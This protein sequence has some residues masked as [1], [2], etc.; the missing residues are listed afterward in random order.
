MRYRFCILIPCLLFTFIYTGFGQEDAG[1]KNIKYE[2]DS[3]F[4]IDSK[5]T[6]GKLDNGL[7]YYI[8]VNKRPENRAELRLVVNVGSVLE[9]DN[10]QGLAHFAEHMAFNG[11]KN[12][13]KQELVDYL[14]SIGMRFG[15]ELNAYTSFD[16]TVYM[17][18]VPSDSIP[19]METAIKILE[20]WAHNVSYDFEE[21]EKE[22]GVIIEEWRLGRGAAARM[23]DQQFPIIFYNS[24]YAE[25]L[26]I[27]KKDILE[28]FEPQTLYDFYKKWYRPELM[29]VI[30]IGDFDKNYIEGLI[31]KQF[32][33]IPKPEQPLDRKLFPVPNH[34]EELFTIVS[35][36]EARRTEVNI[37]FKHEVEEGNTIRDYRKL[38]V[39]NL[40]NMML[41]ARFRELQQQPDPPFLYAYSAKDRVVRSKEFYILGAGVSEDG[42][43]KGLRTILTEA[44]RVK[45]Y[46]FTESELERGKIDILRT[47]EWA[48]NERD[49]SESNSYASEYTRNFLINE[50]IPGIEQEFAIGKQ[51]L[52]GVTIEEINRLA[53]S[54]ITDGNRVITVNIPE[55]EGLRIPTEEELA[56]VFKEAENTEISAYV[57]KMANKPL[58]EKELAKS[59]II[60]TEVIDALEVTEIKLANGV[61]VILKPTNFKNDEVRFDAFSPGGH[62]LVADEEYVAALTATSIIQQSGL[63]E[64]NLIEL[65]KLLTGKIVNVSPYI[66][67]LEEGFSGGA[68]PKDLETMFKLIYLYF[69]SPRIDSTAY[70]SYKNRMKGFL[71]NRKV[72]PEVAYS[73]TIRVTMGQYHHRRRPWK[74]EMF[75]EMD[76]NR[77]IEI[78]KD[79][80]KDASDFTFVFVGNFEIEKITPLIQTYLGSLPS[81]LR[82]EKW[83]DVGV[84]FPTGVISKTVEKGIEQKSRVRLIFTGP[85]K[86]SEQ[87]SYDIGS[88]G[89]ILRIKLREVLREDLGG[90]YGVGVSASPIRRPREQYRITVSFGCNPDRVE[91]LTEQVL[92][93]IDS[94]KTTTVDDIYLK[95]VKETQRRTREKRLKENGFWLGKLTSYYMFD[96]DPEKI[97]EFDK[98][99]DNLSKEA[100]QKAAQ[101]YFTIKNYA[102]FVLY[103][104]K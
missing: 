21:V 57:D 93:Q 83:R 40:Y 63:G 75:R 53:D 64:F 46:G 30:A 80:F 14:E 17:L 26:P 91:E 66:G 2:L 58:L 97:F 102:K 60:K 41:N 27:G 9:E 42:I 88:M 54:W 52:P 76:L 100:I 101:K 69:T 71:A 7:K 15:P 87:N 62:S 35:D 82:Q 37:Y 84:E 47:L 99:V 49:K 34:D 6:V 16:E 79:R 98:Y 94:L 78:Y 72:S 59:P 18:Q 33:N 11:T 20:E 8:R 65:D 55:K 1:Q 77:S 45:K 56:K 10:E 29:A 50:P 61:H 23:R 70:T 22:R 51:Y 103:P 25:R 43:E 38:L 74:E 12:F 19:L 36:K 96:M 86:W 95:K 81:I 68:S 39:D 104:E 5:I 32:S 89:S 92:L 24:R 85:F 4:P 73:D 48:Y 13:Q 3:E 44:L 31:Q 28:S 90:T 67:E